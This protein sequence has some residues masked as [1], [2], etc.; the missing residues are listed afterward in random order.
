MK[1]RQPYTYKDF[2]GTRLPLISSESAEV[3]S[4]SVLNLGWQLSFAN[5]S[6]A[7]LPCDLISAEGCG[8]LLVYIFKPAISWHN[9]ISEKISLEI[10]EEYVNF[11]DDSFE[12]SNLNCCSATQGLFAF[13]CYLLLAEHQQC[14][15]CLHNYIYNASLVAWVSPQTWQDYFPQKTLHFFFP[16]NS[17]LLGEKTIK[18]KRKAAQWQPGVSGEAEI[19]EGTEACPQN[20]SW[21]LQTS[22]KLGVG[23]PSNLWAALVERL[24]GKT[25]CRVSAPRVRGRKIIT[26]YP[27]TPLEN[28]PSKIVPL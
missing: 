10:M 20:L 28:C 8:P 6:A 23:L 15:A 24:A 21:Y 18:K 1:F 7:Q 11:I 22:H 16:E 25:P 12:Q 26:D 3:S 19:L 27:E 5:G 2:W 9:L 4:P 14:F 17:I 13:S